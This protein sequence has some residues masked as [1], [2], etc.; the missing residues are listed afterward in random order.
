MDEIRVLIV[1]DVPF[2]RQFLR[3]CVM[4][5]FPSFH[6]DEAHNGTSAI[7]KLKGEPFDII[8]CDWEMPEVKGDEILKWIRTESAFKDMPFIMVTGNRD[9]EHIMK[10]LQLGVSEY[11]I[12]PVTGDTLS[13]K[14]T[15]ALKDNPKM[16][17]ILKAH[18]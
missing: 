5:G 16:Q 1:D 17:K 12:K 11:I 2:M 3:H 13:K 15:A 8:L 9:K 4:N 18:G 14:M 7:E 10:A 6:T